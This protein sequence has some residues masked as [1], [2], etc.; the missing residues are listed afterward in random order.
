MGSMT[1]SSEILRLIA[2][3]DLHILVEYAVPRG[4][5]KR[6][7]ITIRA[8]DG[9]NVGLSTPQGFQS[10]A[11]ELPRAIFNDYV[12]AK[13]VAQDNTADAEGRAIYRLTDDGWPAPGL[14]DTR[15]S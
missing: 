15:L 12:Q 14:D 1:S 5:L 13:F 6:D 11:I 4:A 3:N 2:E 8:N 7:T 10:N 9:R